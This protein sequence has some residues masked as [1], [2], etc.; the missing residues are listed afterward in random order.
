MTTVTLEFDAEDL[1]T[2]NDALAQ[3]PYYRAAPL[4]NKINTQIR[5]QQAAEQ[6]LDGEAQGMLSQKVERP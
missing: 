4:V 2:I 5:T 3:M 6:S 1:Q